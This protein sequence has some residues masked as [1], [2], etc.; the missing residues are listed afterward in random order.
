LPPEAL[1]PRRWRRCLRQHAEREL[2]AAAPLRRQFH[3]IEAAVRWDREPCPLR[4]ARELLPRQAIVARGAGLQPGDR[5]VLPASRRL[6]LSVLRR[7][8]GERAHC[9][10]THAPGKC[11]G[12]HG[13]APHP[14]QHRWGQYV[15]V[16]AAATELARRRR[17]FAICWR[18]RFSAGRHE[19]RRLQVHRHPS[20]AGADAVDGLRYLGQMGTARPN[21]EFTGVHHRCTANNSGW[22]DAHLL[23]IHEL[24][25]IATSGR[26]RFCARRRGRWVHH[27]RRRGNQELSVCLHIIRV[28]QGRGQSQRRDKIQPEQRR[29]LDLH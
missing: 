11:V 21:V 8:D 16:R 12:V 26:R 28:H 5:L 19:G 4:P 17:L 13:R 25:P 27:E 9:R 22:G 10:P 18:R 23:G 3:P 2:D 20:S 1:H 6:Q 14:T 15:G 24:R 29:H 7:A